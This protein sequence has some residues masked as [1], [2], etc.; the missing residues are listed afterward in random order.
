MN[1]K[2]FLC[3]FLVISFLFALAACKADAPTPDAQSTTAAPATD[4][5]QEYE[6]AQVTEPDENAEP[7]LGH[8]EFDSE[9]AQYLGT[10]DTE[11]YGKLSFYYQE[12]RLVLFDAYNTQ[13]FALYANSYEPHYQGAEV[14]LIGE[15]VNFDGYTDFYLLYSQ[16][17]MNAYYFFWI[18]NMQDRT[19][20]YYL[21]LSS[22]PS[23]EID[24]ERKLITSSDQTD[25]D[26][27]ITTDY[28]WQNGNIVPVGHGERT[29]T[30][31]NE[32]QPDITGPEDA[33]LSLS[34]LDGHIL[35]SVT[36]KMN[37]NT[38]ADWLCRIEDERI[39]RIY[40]ENK[41]TVNKTHRFVF[42]GLAQGTTTVILRYAANWNAEYVAQ[43]ILN[44]TVNPDATLKIVIV[45]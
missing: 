38:K 6:T 23:P 31:A 3:I 16:G 36:M 7:N 33:D 21:P 44:I 32:S 30:P 10:I 9:K 25:F 8:F 40:S 20:E 5:T 4:A 18:W 45:E 15:D 26:T 41:D 19:F 17:N 27:I 2:R 37:E 34:L 22:V 28:V 43:R 39:V 1:N 42:R 14:E 13:R 12:N 35:S 24:K 29:V 11:I